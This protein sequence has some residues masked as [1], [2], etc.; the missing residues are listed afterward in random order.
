MMD[1]VKSGEKSLLLGWKTKQ[2]IIC[3]LS[4]SQSGHY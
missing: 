1:Q 4:E 3:D 2:Y